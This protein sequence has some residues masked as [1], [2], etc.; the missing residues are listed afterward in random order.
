MTLSRMSDPDDRPRP[1]WRWPA[2]TIVVSVYAA[3]A[4]AVLLPFGLLESSRLPVSAS[5]DVGQQ[6]WWL[7]LALHELTHG[8]WSFFTAAIDHPSGVNV[9]DNASMPLLG[10]LMTPVTAAFGPVAA[11]ML[12]LRI[13]HMLSA[14]SAFW[15][16]RRLGFG[17]LGAGAA[18]LV[19]GFGPAMGPPTAQHAFLVFAPL[20]PLMLYLI[21]T[22][23]SGLSAHEE[24]SG[25]PRAARPAL[26]AGL[27]L[28]VLAALQYLI[29]SEVL[30]STLLM[31]G[32]VIVLVALW[33]WAR[34]RLLVFSMGNL[35]RFVAGAAVS[36][37]PLLAYPVGYMLLGHAHVSGPVQ[38]TDQP[39][40]SLL[41]ILLPTRTTGDLYGGQVLAGL[42]HGWSVGVGLW[43][44]LNIGYLGLLALIAVLV[45]V[46]CRRDPRVRLVSLFGAAAFV[47]ELGPRLSLSGGELALR[48]PFVL[49]YRVPILQDL[50]PTRL[51]LLVDLAVGFLLAAGVDR[52]LS[53]ACSRT[54]TGRRRT[55]GSLTMTARLAG[56]AA[57]LALAAPAS[58][59]TVQPV[60]VSR[61]ASRAI[62]RRIPTGAIVLA[63]PYPSFNHE[64]AM[65]LQAQAGMNFDLLGGYAIRPLGRSR[66]AS[67]EPLLQAP[68]AI[69]N[70]LKWHPV[71][72]RAAAAEL[73]GWLMS[74]GVTRLLVL[75]TSP[76]GRTMATV[77]EDLFGRPQPVGGWLL[78]RV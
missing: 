41:S 39:G 16:A 50:E 38:A 40:V 23:L 27:L 74:E 8:N 11:Y 32:C 21:Y 29:S 7:A 30:V 13:G 28:G 37:V 46:V 19:Y 49:L 58:G 51:A 2:P 69:A 47:L 71:Q 4:W 5:Q 67:K 42:W 15:V 64:P 57:A 73:P 20:P 48:L 75:P 76:E 70:L 9:L 54:Q 60:P 12:L 44:T 26:R 52:C 24:P 59:L 3:A 34:R 6:V 10:L 56:I 68:P 53:A 65:L 14:C 78:W 55:G 35:G 17:R 61:S 31:G 36:A 33:S 62:G 43:P 66:A 1:S 72:T 18:G 45:A 22:G 63:V 77:A 25:T